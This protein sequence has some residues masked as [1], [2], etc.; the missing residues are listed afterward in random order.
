M[1]KKYLDYNPYRANG[2][3]KQQFVEALQSTEDYQ[4]VINYLSSKKNKR[5]LCIFIFGTSFGMRITDLINLKWKYVLNEDLSIKDSMWIQESKRKRVKEI[6]FNPLVKK[7]I[8][9][10]LQ[11]LEVQKKSFQRDYLGNLLPIQISLEKYMFPSQKGHDQPMTVPN[12]CRLF[13][14]I[15]ADAGVDPSHNYCTHTM[16]K[17][18]GKTL[19]DQGYDVW[20][21]SKLLGHS[22]MQETLCYIGVT[23]QKMGKMYEGLFNEIHLE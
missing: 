1:A 7:V 11:S 12:A 21:I 8:A 19:Y 17:T 16:R 3:K 20:E 4:K 2:T 13:K 23:K 10:Y 15:F 6:K 18:T 9:L 14:K 22:S 5:N